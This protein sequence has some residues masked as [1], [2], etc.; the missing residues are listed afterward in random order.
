MTAGTP[1]VTQLYACSTSPIPVACLHRL[2]CSAGSKS[3]VLA[4]ETSP[5]LFC[6]SDPADTPTELQN[7]TGP[8]YT[9]TKPLHY[10]A[11]HP[12]LLSIP[13]KHE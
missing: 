2:L 4:L 11:K 3:T 9:S 7:Q 13:I 10:H 12:A 8:S 5:P 1:P 6:L